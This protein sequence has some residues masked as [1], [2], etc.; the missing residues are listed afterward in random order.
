MTVQK[1]NILQG[2][3]GLIFGALDERSLAWH[4][5]KRC[6]ECGADI[7]LTNTPQA[8]QLGTLPNLAQQAGVP[9]VPCDATDINDIRHLL[10]QAQTLLGGSIDFVLHSVAQSLNLRRHRTYEKVNY[11]YFLKTLDISA[12]SLHKILQAALDMNAI[13][14]GGSVVTLT[15]LASERY[16]YGYN[17][18]ADAKAMLESIVRQ[19]GAIYGTAHGVRVNA[20][21]QSAT[22]TKAGTQWD[23]QACFSRYVNDL[24]PLGAA[25]ADDCADL[26]VTLFSDFTRKVTMQTIYNDGGFAHT[27]LTGQLMSEFR[28]TIDN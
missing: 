19:M 3:K 12:L 5:A 18:M 9:I 27:M 10:T 16:L 22:N 13:S 2:K 14:Q 1:C 23:E 24:S 6:M 15:Y 28:N 11:D 20:I 25:D 7:V 8:L 17:D 26:C 4:V 21:S